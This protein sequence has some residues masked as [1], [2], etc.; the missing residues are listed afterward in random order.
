[1]SAESTDPSND[2]PA[3]WETLK[4][5][6]T[7]NCRVFRVLKKTCRHPKRGQIADFSVLDAPDWV[8]VVAET[9]NGALVMVRQFRYGSEALSLEVPG[10]VME[11]GEDPVEAARRELQEETGYVG[12]KAKLLGRVHPNPA[13]QN[14][15]CHLVMIEGVELSAEQSWDEHEEIEVELM[16]RSTVLDLAR[17]GGITHSLA[18]NALSLYDSE[19]RLGPAAV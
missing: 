8:N 19:R 10:G 18:L 11:P 9:T 7:A 5:E 3:H 12:G 13:I 4:T 15:H 14:N 6:V 17:S 16:S 2:G 1:M